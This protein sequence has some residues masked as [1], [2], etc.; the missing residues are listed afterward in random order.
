MGTA[1][2]NKLIDAVKNGN[3][4]E[5]RS[6]LKPGLVWYDQACRC[7]SKN[8]KW[9]D[10]FNSCLPAGESGNSEIVTGEWRKSK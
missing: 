5:V 8:V 3:I 1:K 2:D 10:T 9:G 4:A 7:L 6:L